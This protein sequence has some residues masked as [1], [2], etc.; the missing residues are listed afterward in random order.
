MGDSSKFLGPPLTAG[1]RPAVLGYGLTQSLHTGQVPLFMLGEVEAMRADPQ[2]SLGIAILR[3]PLQRVRFKVINCPRSD[4]ARFVAAQ[5]KQIWNTSARKLITYLEYGNAAGEPLY[6]RENGFV[7]FDQI[8][9]VYARDAVP[10]MQRG[11]VVGV[12][13]K[14]SAAPL[15]TGNG[16]TG[17]AAAGTI[18]LFPPR[19]FWLAHRPR[20]GSPF[21]Y[22]RCYGAWWPWLE[23]RGRHGATAI[24]QGWYVKNAFSGIVIRHPLGTMEGPGGTLISNQDYAREIAEKYQTG[25]VLALP[26]TR[27][28]D[29]KEYL[30][31]IEAPKVNGDLAGVRDYSTDLDVEILQG[32]EIPPE[33][34]RAAETGSG[35]SGR[36]VPFI[37]FLVG[38]DEIAA[39]ISAAIVR[40][41]LRPM[42]EH[43]FGP[44]IPF[45]VEPVSLLELLGAAQEGG[46]QPGAQGQPGQ[47]TPDAPNAER[48]PSAE[49]VQMSLESDRASRENS[50][51]I[52]DQIID[53]GAQAGIIAAGRVRSKLRKL[54]ARRL[55]APKLLDEARRLLA[56]YEPILASAFSD[57]LVA[58]WLAGAARATRGLPPVPAPG[59]DPLLPAPPAGLPPALTLGRGEDEPEPA[60]RLPL[61]EAAAR[62]L[63]S[64]K[65]MTRE[66]YDQ[67]SSEA[68]ATAF[69]AARVASEESLG[70]LAEAL[71]SGVEHGGTLEDFRAK[72]TEA[73][74]T[75]VLSDGHVQN[76]FRTNVAQ[77]YTTG[78]METLAHP[79]VADE[80]PYLQYS[81]VHDSRVRHDHLQLERLGLDGTAIYRR[82]DPLWERFTPPW[83]YQC[84]CNVIPLSVEDAAAAGVQEAKEWIERGF[85][86]AQPA[87]VPSPPFNPPAGWSTRTVVRLALDDEGHEHGKGGRFAPKGQG[88]PSGGKEPANKA[89]KKEHEGR[90]DPADHPKAK[91]EA[92]KKAGLQLK[93]R[94]KGLFQRGS[95]RGRIELRKSAKAV[96]SKIGKQRWDKLPPKMQKS[97]AFTHAMATKTLYAID[98]P[99]RMGLNLTKQVARE[100][101]LSEEHVQKVARVVNTVD[102]LSTL[103]VV[104]VY[105][106]AAK[107]LVPALGPIAG[108][109]PVAALTYVGY[110]TLRNPFAT[111]RAARGLMKNFKG[112]VTTHLSHGDDQEAIAALL[113]AYAAHK[114]DEWWEALLHAALDE[115]HDLR[116]A[117]T[118]ADKAREQHEQHEAPADEDGGVQLSLYNDYHGPNPPGPDWM[119]VGTGPKGGKI[120]RHKPS[121]GILK[122]VVHKV[123]G[124]K[125][126]DVQEHKKAEVH[127]LKTAKV[128]SRKPK[129]GGINTSE[130][131]ELE[132]GGKG[133][134][135]PSAGESDGA[136]GEGMREGAIPKGGQYRREAASYSVA[137]ALGFADLVPTT[138]I[139]EIEGGEGSIQEFV[140]GCKD[141]CNVKPKDARFDGEEDNARA[142]AFDYLTANTDRHTGNWLV[143]Q[144]GPR[145]GKLVLIDN[146][147]S[148][149]TRHGFKVSNHE[150]LDSAIDRKLK[151][152]A[153]LKNLMDKWPQMEKALRD[154]G[155]ED[156]AVELAKARAQKLQQ[157]AR[158][159]GSFTDLWSVFSPTSAWDPKKHPVPED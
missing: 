137:E 89:P 80:F 91:A 66:E 6:K 27:D 152:P 41:I 73:L 132:G 9:D 32:F 153:E 44:G 143:V 57:S 1:Y 87:W 105:T 77:A 147:M 93:Q 12:Q 110:S 60:I 39:E 125:P 86:P 2:I 102:Q 79:L 7:V 130:M 58:A 29:T 5:H 155:I 18:N 98:T 48:P 56:S 28:P 65:I 144:D 120:W 34:A 15:V 63:A 116:A 94:V 81:A 90:G 145:R 141:A 126:E 33:V 129:G 11:G 51:A 131:V 3:A 121:Q 49:R 40:W 31:S 109:I 150:L 59:T 138:T 14:N 118:M 83:D 111:I 78:L 69:T 67:L 21:G 72:V 97:I 70:R 46:G 45:D 117:I 114:E 128:L 101:G 17:G 42:V 96:A 88:G 75:G 149:P 133:I 8:R 127:K 113:Q 122:R 4:V 103:P 159:G 123:L 35:W 54:I 92:V 19:A 38:E 156:E 76:I 134:Y 82:D 124:K 148:F 85:P 108:Y 140:A 74:G 106:H 52:V 107:A 115:T 64:R 136:G 100:R 84:R 22:S 13:V 36:S 10:L 151:V 26:S 55:P 16:P 53:Q 23:K 43:N 157:I 112:A 47:P 158:K 99:L 119:L 71:A 61:I 30:W 142:A 135:K 50:A 25:A 37:V 24:R 95:Q 20:N 146:G 104:G 154:S 139:R 68:K 62:D